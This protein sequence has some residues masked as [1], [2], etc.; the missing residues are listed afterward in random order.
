MMTVNTK[1]NLEQRA[2]L[3][4]SL[5]TNLVKFDVGKKI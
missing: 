2:I 1:Q 4:S 3:K 5:T